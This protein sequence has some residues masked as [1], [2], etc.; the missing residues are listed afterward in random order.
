MSDKNNN[1]QDQNKQDAEKKYSID[2]ENKYGAHGTEED[3]SSNFS[4]QNSEHENGEQK[5]NKNI[6][7]GNKSYSDSFS[8]EDNSVSTH[9]Y[10]QNQESANETNTSVSETLTNQNQENEIRQS[11]DLILKSFLYNM[12]YFYPEYLDT[13]HRPGFPVAKHCRK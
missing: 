10:N 2:E 1:E 3:I 13:H 6:E 9:E 12:L 4:G 8:Q 11:D 7:Q 5:E